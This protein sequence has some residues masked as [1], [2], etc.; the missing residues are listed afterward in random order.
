MITSHHNHATFPRHILRQ[1][2][3]WAGLFALLVGLAPTTQAAKVLFVTT[4]ALRDTVKLE[5][6][7]QAQGH[8]L[9]IHDTAVS[10]NAV[11]AAEYAGQGY[12]LLI[13]DEVIGSG[14]V[15]DRFRN[16]PIPVINL[17]GFLYSNG[18]SSFNAGTGLTGGT[19]SNAT[20]AA[21]QHAAGVADFGQVQNTT[22]IDIV[23]PSHPLA[24]GLP[25]GPVDVWDPATP[26][27]DTELG[28]DHLRRRPDVHYQRACGRDRSRLRQ[29]ICGVWRGC[30]CD[31]RGWYN[32]KSGPLGPPALERHRYRGA[33]DD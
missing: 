21:Q 13:V 5:N 15:A 23:D 18:R 27:L 20:W 26:P 28:G 24:A 7:L 29:W 32:N 22:A 8:D 25:A 33:R 10:G 12:E 4:G 14:A 17:E 19:F 3:L 1:S 16:S 6:I 9:T 31:E 11:T 2:C 30:R